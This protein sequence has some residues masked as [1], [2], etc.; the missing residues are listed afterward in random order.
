MAQ[1][2]SCE[3]CKFFKNT[4]S[5]LTPSVAAFACLYYDG[6]GFAMPSETKRNWWKFYYVF[7]GNGKASRRS[8]PVIS[9]NFKENNGEGVL[10]EKFQN[11]FGKSFS[12]RCEACYVLIEALNTSRDV[13]ESSHLDY[14]SIH[15]I[16]HLSTCHLFVLINWLLPY[17]F[18]QY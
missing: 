10:F 9:K 18:K 2:F 11:Q 1:V 17:W 16:F 12:F 6:E 13:W 14:D 15:G 4:F 7:F 3:F 8:L 5:F